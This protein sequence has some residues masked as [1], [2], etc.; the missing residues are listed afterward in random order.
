[1]SSQVV[2]FE[3]PEDVVRAF[4]DAA[5]SMSM[6]R[7]QVLQNLME[8]YLSYDRSFRT[9]VAKGI[10]QADASLLIDHAEIEARVRRWEREAEQSERHF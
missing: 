6:S 1:M 9:S 3:A 8:H 2:T 10:E 4:D 5:A 7:E